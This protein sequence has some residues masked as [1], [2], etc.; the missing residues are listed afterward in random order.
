MYPVLRWPLTVQLGR[1]LA[2]AEGRPKP[3]LDAHVPLARH[4][5]FRSGVIPADLRQSLLDGLKA[6]DR[7]RIRQAYRAIL[8]GHAETEDDKPTLISPHDDPVF[9]R[10]MQGES[11]GPR[12]QAIDRYLWRYLP[13]SK[14][15]FDLRTA[16]AVSLAIAGAAG[17]FLTADWLTRDWREAGEPISDPIQ[18]PEMVWLPGG[19]FQMGSPEGVGFP[20]EEP[21][22]AVTVQPFAISK[23]EVTKEQYDAFLEDTDHRPTGN[24]IVWD[25]EERTATEIAPN[26]AGRYDIP[27]SDAA[28]YGQTHPAVCVSWHDAQAYI[29]WLNELADTSE[30]NVYRLPTEAEWEYAARAGSTG[31][32]YWSGVSP[33]P[34]QDGC[35]YANG[36]DQTLNEAGLGDKDWDYSGCT[37]G[38]TLTSPVGIYRANAF[39]LHDLSGNVWEWV[40]DCWHENYE[41]APMDGSAWLSQQD[42]DC[43]RRVVRGGSWSNNPRDP[44]F[45]LRSRDEP[46]NRFNGIGFRPA[47][48]RLTP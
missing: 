24:C 32:W 46:D 38:S 19:T 15:L 10:F 20:D 43:S 39:G 14:D 31:D 26:A 25:L 41:G 36:A 29:A 8:D 22:H 21:Q 12:E 27:S 7:R 17:A 35:G 9:T 28:P 33:T 34:A 13:R 44:P 16:I 30:T 40:E 47:R 18:L 11:P 48:T 1:A 42:G 2:Q 45:R 6:R 3:D 23:Y 4:P 37:D 5:W